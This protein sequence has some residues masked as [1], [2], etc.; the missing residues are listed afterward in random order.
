MQSKATWFGFS[1]QYYPSP[2]AAYRRF[3]RLLMNC[4]HC[5]AWLKTTQVKTSRWH[6]R[7]TFECGYLRLWSSR[8][9][10]YKLN[11]SFI[12]DAHV[13]PTPGPNGIQFKCKVYGFITTSSNGLNN[14][15]SSSW[16]LRVW[17]LDTRKIISQ[18]HKMCVVNLLSRLIPYA[19][20]AATKKNFILAKPC[21]LCCL[22][23][24][25]RSFI[26]AN[27]KFKPDIVK[28]YEISIEN[29]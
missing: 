2:Q 7:K 25:M 26:P 14:Y 27:Y 10:K 15:N 6:H 11:R 21:P 20:K 16:T 22:S 17:L 3:F 24:A 8:L 4:I 28:E 9:K 12:S 13:F 23:A 5:L 1:N 29:I 18:L 19:Y